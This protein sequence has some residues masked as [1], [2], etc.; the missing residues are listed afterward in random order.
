MIVR[1][2][3]DR[4]G[5]DWQIAIT[6]ASVKRVRDLLSFDLCDVPGLSKIDDDV[7]LL[8]DLAYCL[9]KDQADAAGVDDVAF[10]RSFDGPT[11][12]ALQRAFWEEI[13]HFFRTRGRSN[14]AKA[15]AKFRTLMQMPIPSRP[16]TNSPELSASNPKERHSENLSGWST[17]SDANGGTTPPVKSLPSSK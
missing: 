4:H 11:I 17:D 8:I 1:A 16:L 12:E 13:H 5:K 15:I 7:G 3:K 6:V 10:G 14:A 9:V 2:I